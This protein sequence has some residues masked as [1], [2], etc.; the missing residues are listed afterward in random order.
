MILERKILL[1]IIL[2]RTWTQINGEFGVAAFNLLGLLI[3]CSLDF[4]KE[5]PLSSSCLQKNIALI[6]LSKLFVSTWEA[7]QHHYIDHMWR[8]TQHQWQNWRRG[9]RCPGHIS[10]LYS[11]LGNTSRSF[12]CNRSFF[13]S[14]HSSMIFL[15][16]RSLR[17]Y[18]CR[19]CQWA[20]TSFHVTGSLSTCI[21]AHS[22]AEF[23]L[24]LQTW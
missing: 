16:S 20:R 24:I 21:S 11:F 14:A 17:E 19:A 13:A 23:C 12:I 3:L 10:S 6:F 5:W 1:I 2:P 4:F 18:A 7:I 8:P 22:L 9:Y 15:S